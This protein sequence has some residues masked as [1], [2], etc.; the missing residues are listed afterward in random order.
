[1]L[2]EFSQIL[3]EL[4]RKPLVR[5]LTAPDGRVLPGLRSPIAG[6]EWPP[7]ADHDPVAWTRRVRA[8]LEQ[9]AAQ[10]WIWHGLKRPFV[11]PLGLGLLASST[12]VGLSYVLFARDPAGTIALAVVLGLWHPLF[13]WLGTRRHARKS[14]SSTGSTPSYGRN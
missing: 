9:H 5:R 12:I 3:A 11:L 14:S 2:D 8:D 1:V 6:E 7:A 13:A 10:R 4:D